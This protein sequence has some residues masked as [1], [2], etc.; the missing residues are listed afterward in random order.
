[1]G[2]RRPAPYTSGNYS[3]PSSLISFS[4]PAAAPAADRRPLLPNTRD[5]PAPDT[6][7]ALGHGGGLV[8][9]VRYLGLPTPAHGSRDFSTSSNTSIIDHGSPTLLP[10]IHDDEEEDEEL[11]LPAGLIDRFEA[12][13]TTRA[14]PTRVFPT[15][16]QRIVVGPEVERMM[17]S[18]HTTMTREAWLRLGGFGASS[19]S[20]PGTDALP[21]SPEPTLTEI[22]GG[23]EEERVVVSL[24]KV[25]FDESSREPLESPVAVRLSAPSET[26]NSADVVLPVLLRNPRRS[27]RAKREMATSRVGPVRSSVS[28]RSRTSPY[29]TASDAQASIGS[30][31]ST[32]PSESTIAPDNHKLRLALAQLPSLGQLPTLSQG[33]KS[34]SRKKSPNHVPRPRNAY[35]LYRSWS[36]ARGNSSTVEG[37]STEPALTL[38]AQIVRAWRDLPKEE[39]QQWNILAEEEKARHRILYPDYKYKPQK[40]ASLSKSRGARKVGRGGRVRMTR[41]SSEESDVDEGDYRE[42]SAE[43]EPEER[44]RRTIRRQYTD[45]PVIAWSTSRA[46]NASGAERDGRGQSPANGTA[47]ESES[48]SDESDYTPQFP[49]PE[50]NSLRTGALERMLSPAQPTSKRRHT[51]SNYSSQPRSPP[52]LSSPPLSPESLSSEAGHRPTKQ[53]RLSSSPLFTLATSEARPAR[54][55]VASRDPG[56]RA[57]HQQYEQLGVGSITALL[58]DFPL[59]PAVIMNPALLSPPLLVHPDPAIS[60]SYYHSADSADRQSISP[61]PEA[62]PSSRG[63]WVP[64]RT[65]SDDTSNRTASH[66]LHLSLPSLLEGARVE[67]MGLVES[68]WSEIQSAFP[69]A[70][71]SQRSTSAVSSLLGGRVASVSHRELLAQAEEHEMELLEREFELPLAGAI[72]AQGD[73]IDESRLG[74]GG[75]ARESRLNLRSISSAFDLDRSF[76]DEE[77]TFITSPPQSLRPTPVL[78]SRASSLS[79]L[80]PSPQYSSTSRQVSSSSTAARDFPAARGRGDS[81]ESNESTETTFIDGYAEHDGEGNE[82]GY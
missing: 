30:P 50:S 44:S 6:R 1:M 79:N 55:S 43:R 76:L 67:R 60:L 27:T 29:P 17:P 36:L 61:V 72:D 57:S 12:S 10:Y 4:Y 64:T 54:A 28:T 13:P 75:S 41:E 69:P 18:P 24:R 31:S 14:S 32:P 66:Q 33:T 16:S 19:A 11:V 20:P 45:P 53:S 23:E 52:F 26:I 49:L 62:R 51:S 77:D 65:H 5:C 42:L 9:D 81:T 59:P 38:S 34:H 8:P 71:R 22:P 40:V 3:Y 48:A 73:R 15:L 21:E 46:D 35:I 82:E 39:R 25:E 68:R 74:I 63:P 47:T 58:V 37:T 56:I 70:G 2:P 80:Q 78:P 7:T